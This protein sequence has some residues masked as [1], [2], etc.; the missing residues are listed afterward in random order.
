MSVRRS[1]KNHAALCGIALLA[2]AGGARADNPAATVNVN[3]NANRLAISPYIYGSNWLDTASIDDLN[4]SVNRRGGNAT[5]TYNWQLN[6]TNRGGDWYFESLSDGPEVPSLSADQFIDATKAGGAE[7]M[8]TIPMVDWVAKVGPNRQGL[9]PYSVAKYGAQTKTDPWWT[10]AGN[11]ILVS[12]GSRV[13]NDPND[14]YVP[15][16]PAFQKQWVEYLVNKYGA[17]TGDGIK[18]YLTDNE[19]GVWPANHRPIVPV[20][21]T[22]AGIRDRI[23]AYGGVVK[24][25]D[26][27]ALLVGPE[28]WGWPNYFSSPYDTQFGGG[29]DRAANGGWDFMPW[30]LKELKAHEDATGRRLLDVFSLHYYPQYS[31]FSEGDESVAAQLK[32]NEC[33]RDLWDPNYFSTSWISNR[34]RLIPRMKEWVNANYPGTKLAITEYSW[35]AEGH[36]SGAIAQ[37]D[38]LGIFGREGV[39]LATFWGGLDP[40]RPIYKTFKLYR[41]YDGNNSTFGDTSVS[42]T[43]ANPDNVS[44]FAAQRSGDGALTI[45]VINKYLTDTTPIAVNLGG[46]AA[47]GTAEVWQLTAANTIDRLA[48]ADVVGNSISLVAPAQ[49]VTLLVVPGTNLPP[50]NLRARYTFEGTVQDGSGNGFHGTAAAPVYASGKTGA[51]AAQFDG[52]G[53][54]VTI[55]ASVTDDFTVTMWVKTTDNGGWSG[56]HWWA[57]KGLVDGEIGGGGADWGTALVNGKF[58]LGVGSTGGDVTVASS[59]NINNG[60][61]RHVAATRDNTTGEMRVYVD[62]VLSG[63]GT[64]PTGSRS[65]PTSLRIGGLLPGSNYLNGVIDDVRLY[66]RVLAAEEIAETFGPAP[67]AP[68]GLTATAESNGFITLDWSAS[69][70]ADSYLVKRATS[71]GGVYSVVSAPTGTHFID[72][73]VNYGTT[74]YYVV[75]AVNL[76]DESAASVEIS[77]TPQLTPPPVPASLAGTVTTLGQVDLSWTAAPRATLYRIKRS[78]TIGGPYAEIGTSATTAFSDTTASLG[79]LYHYVV[80]A[81]NTAGASADSPELAAR[82]DSLVLHLKFDET[83]GSAANDSSGLARHADLLNGPAFASGKLGNALTFT[84]TSSHYATLPAGIVSTLTDFTIGTWVKPASL[85]TWARVFDFGGG[86]NNFMYLTTRQSS[87]GR[88]MFSI[89]VGGGSEQQVVAGSALST[90]AWTHVAVRLSGSTATIYLNGVA[91][92]TNNAITFRPADMGATTQNY[93]GKSQFSGDPHYNGLLDDFRIYARALSTDEIATLAAGQLPAPQNLGASPGDS[94]ITLAWSPVAGAT[95]YRVK[96]SAIE[97]GIYTDLAGPLTATTYTDTGLSDGATWHYTVTAQGLAGDGLASASASAT[98]YTAVEKW[99]LAYFGTAAN[100]GDA[101]DDADPDA[102]GWTNHQEY[103]S[104]TAPDDASS[105]LRIS[106]LRVDGDDMVL[107]FDT[108]SGRSYRVERSLTLEAGSW[109]TVQD[110]IAGTG[111]PVEVRDTDGALP[112]RRFY[113]LVVLF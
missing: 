30:L 93:L 15:N 95:G 108:V 104:G 73:G 54:S 49:S 55:P 3:A 16:S 20:G 41:N 113:R 90:S 10:D 48:D 45:M 2:V 8:I 105:S 1:S 62:G 111:A 58:V 26:P 112:E 42:A 12:D 24:D 75:T 52:S 9:T 100:F 86:T 77:S 107:E 57:G 65:W 22:M 98:T 61:W 78:T 29:T 96:R 36:I 25:V 109:T 87:T 51:Q 39:Y 72:T 103:V 79:Q 68:T 4:I 23:I 14:A 85:D 59:A 89:K 5:T 84:R 17:S 6:C 13:V 33:T 50:S 40:A 43:V 34:V 74:Y 82:S 76:S 18:F 64:G 81:E 94:S 32:R 101:A 71:P 44:A 38:V 92:G 37:A 19:H 106:E 102:D 110:G 91:S 63:S 69:A 99:R 80:S 88:P 21:P 47:S 46:F 97:G 27:N 60:V 35:G 11:G 70:A 66:D 7:T 56:A 53:P 28:E 67:T 31:E 83:S